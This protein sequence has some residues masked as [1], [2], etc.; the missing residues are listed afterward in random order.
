M[1][2]TRH[3]FVANSDRLE[4][5][6]AHS[7]QRLEWEARNVDSDMRA[8]LEED[9][10]YFMHQSPSTPCLSVIRKAKGVW[11]EDMAGRRYMD[12]HGG[13]SH[14]IGYGHPR[15]IKA[16]KQQLDDLPLS[17]RRYTNEPAIALARKLAAITPG[18]L[19]KTLFAPS[20][21]DA[22]EMAMKTARHATGKFKTVSFWDS[23]HGSGFGASSVGGR[24]MYRSHGVGPMLVG[25]EHVHSP[26]CYRCPYGYR[27]IGGKPDFDSCHMVCAE[28]LIRVL[29]SEGDVSAVIAEPMMATP[30]PPPAGFWKAV[31]EACDKH[32]ALLIFDEIPTGLGKTGKMF[33][34]EHDDVVPDILV[35]GKSLGGC[36]V[37]IAAMIAKPELDVAG[38]LG[39][40]HFT[41]EKNPTTARA[42]LT[43]IEIIEDEELVENA[44]LIGERTLERLQDMMDR[45]HLIGDVRG[46]GLMI[47]IELV[48]DHDTKEKAV[49]EI[50]AL[51]YLALEKGLS[52]KSMLDSVITLSPPLIITDEQMDEALK[53]IDEC[54]TEVERDAPL[55]PG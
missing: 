44:R 2:S 20:G 13:S 28:L 45:H 25:T 50:E 38:A 43:T 27:D 41:H 34:C 53:I 39:L 22:M 32:G 14:H 51:M 19:G 5:E 33:S 29:D 37:P 26:T 18:E 21:S 35:I 10:R 31:R 23:F 17:P 54:L 42:G 47:G 9:A 15:L 8:V 40:G 52:F 11:I 12:F 55:C 36:A 3:G 30:N 46:R 49:E 1:D 48:R 24:K 4:T 6:I 16:I 7:P